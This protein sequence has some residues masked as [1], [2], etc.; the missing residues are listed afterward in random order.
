MRCSNRLQFFR[1]VLIALACSLAPA[2]AF[3]HAVLVASSPAENATVHGPSVAVDLRFNSRVDGARSHVT[4]AALGS[5]SWTKPLTMDAQK[6][7]QELRGNMQL[8]PGK[9]EIRWQALAPDGHL[10]R[11]AIPFTVQ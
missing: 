7:P 6:S 8:E 2:S 11:G 1:T 9:Y 4:I 5:H 10:T 3:A